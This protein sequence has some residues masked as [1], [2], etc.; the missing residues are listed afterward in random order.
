MDIGSA[1]KLC[2]KTKGMTQKELAIRSTLSDSYLCLIENNHREV[3]LHNLEL[4][5]KGLEIPLSI[6][7]LIASDTAL[8]KEINVTQT[9]TFKEALLNLINEME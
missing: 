2:R 5:A 8:T 1:I 6:I 3:T 9:I 7:V 4:I